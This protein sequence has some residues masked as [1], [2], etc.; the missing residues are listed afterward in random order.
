MTAN[1]ENDDL[2]PLL[3]QA[4]GTSEP[5]DQFVDRLHERL[6]VELADSQASRVRSASCVSQ[7]GQQPIPLTRRILTV[8]NLTISAG[9]L[10]AAAAVLLIVALTPANVTLADAVKCIQEAHTLSFRR[11]VTSPKN[12]EHWIAGTVYYRNDGRERCEQENGWIT[13][14]NGVENGILLD[15]REMQA[16][17]SGTF[18]YIAAMAI[19]HPVSY[20]I[21]EITDKVNKPTR[22][23]GEKTFAGR[24][25][26]G[27][28]WSGDQETW[29]IWIDKTNAQP[30]L[31][32]TESQT[33]G[34]KQRTR[35]S[36]IR[37]NPYIDD[38]MFSTNVPAGYTLREPKRP[39]DRMNFRKTK[40]TDANGKE[41]YE[42]HW[43]TGK[44]G[45]EPKT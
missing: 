19:E 33:N 43:W 25:V 38:S 37:L 44:P 21:Q 2:G 14:A 30:V 1:S 22:E 27:F 32:E 45:E 18:G 35:M 15:A 28:L 40:K 42:Y 10:S 41:Y 7:R 11:T 23:L 36:D 4:Y 26:K 17:M 31:I 16:T 5:T 20:W 3:Q 29:T 24:D 8:K 9:V 12:P 39:E 13:V 34:V 6:Q